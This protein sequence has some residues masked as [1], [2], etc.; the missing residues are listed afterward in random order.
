MTTDWQTKYEE[1]DTHW[2]K[3]APSPGLVEFLK[4]NPLDGRVLVAGCGFGHD[5]RAIAAHG[6]EVL[7]L[8]IAPGAVDGAQQ[9]PVVGQESFR[10]GSLM[11]LATSLT[12]QFDWVWEHTLFCAIDRDQRTA[13]RDA[14]VAALK[15]SGHFLAIFY[16]ITDNEGDG[17]PFDTNRDELD[18]LFG[19]DLTLLREWV[20]GTNYESRQ[21]KELMHLYQKPTHPSTTTALP[22]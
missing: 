20:P 3:G 10:L 12:G 15:P 18:A 14:V 11:P 17:P 2:D 4:K 6:A 9:F 5:V 13:Y 19:N 7:G 1:G 8:D 21:G 22:S 16:I